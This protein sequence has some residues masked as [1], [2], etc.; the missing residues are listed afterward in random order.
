[1]E[2]SRHIVGNIDRSLEYCS[3]HPRDTF[4]GIASEVLGF[5]IGIGSSGGFENA[6]DDERVIGYAKADCAYG[7]EGGGDGACYRI[8]WALVVEVFGGFVSVGVKIEN[9][10]AEEED[11]QSEIFVLQYP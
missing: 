1:M 5:L 11:E 6:G 3:H 10:E 4:L 9:S 8:S 7:S 2:S